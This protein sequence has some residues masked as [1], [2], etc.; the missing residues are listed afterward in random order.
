[1]YGLK[2]EEVSNEETMAI[3]SNLKGPKTLKTFAPAA[4][5]NYLKKYHKEWVISVSGFLNPIK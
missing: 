4:H 3:F 2:D 1:M 5:E